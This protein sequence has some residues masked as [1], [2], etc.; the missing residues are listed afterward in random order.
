MAAVCSSHVMNTWGAIVKFEK[1]LQHS[2]PKQ[3]YGSEENV[4]NWLAM[5]PEQ[6][7]QICIN[8]NLLATDEEILWEVLNTVIDNA[9]EMA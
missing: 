6:R 1:W 9:N 8:V 5:S 4:Q 7:T 3:C 2:A